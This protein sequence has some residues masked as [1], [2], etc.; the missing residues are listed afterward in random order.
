VTRLQLRQLDGSLQFTVSAERLLLGRSA[1][2]DL[3]VPSPSVSRRHAELWVEGEILRLRDLGS[4]NGITVNGEPLTQG[5]AT[6]NDLVEFGAIAFRVADASNRS[7]GDLEE[8]IPDGLSLRS[9]PILLPAEDDKRNAETLRR[10]LEVAA[11]LSGPVPL[12]RVCGAVADLVFTQ[13]AADRVVVLLLETDDAPRP[14]AWRNRVGEGAPRVPRIIADRAIADRQPV[15]TE[16]AQEDDRFQSRSVKAAAVRSALCVPLLDGSERPLGILY[17]DTI[18]RERP[19]DEKDANALLAFGG[20]A[21]AAIGRA[22][23]AADVERERELRA[24]F[25]RFFA[26][27]V[28]EMIVASGGSTALTG[29]QVPVA[30]VFGDLRGFTALSE[31]HSPEATA[32]LL[33][34]YFA[35]VGEIVFEQ[36]GTLDKFIGDGFLA[37]WGAPVACSDAADRALAAARAIGREVSLLGAAA[38]GERI[39]AGFG[40][41]YGEVFA[42]NV[43]SSR[44][45]E[46][47]V[48]GDAVNVA[49][50]L[51]EAAA[52]QEILLTAAFANQ[53]TTMT[54]LIRLPDRPVRGRVQPVAVF[55]ASPLAPAQSERDDRHEP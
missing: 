22:R 41:S 13:V 29:A 15:L 50:R 46:Y 12:E 35:I 33:G 21:A 48:V 28:A 38:G 7:E 8:D 19:F 47:T 9:L 44:R 24:G 42:G 36:N 20:L 3:V 1:G 14:V 17:A 54:G 53:L 37:V 4:A 51:C 40:L 30:V 39:S 49:S 32:A 23:F 55:S 52:P 2:C 45:V 25:E 10:L 43:G 11:D 31:S 18:T 5:S 34:E 16:S 6:L 27:S 26:P